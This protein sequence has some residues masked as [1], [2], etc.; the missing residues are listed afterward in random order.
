MANSDFKNKIVLGI[1]V[2]RTGIHD[3]LT[4]KKIFEIVLRVGNHGI[5]INKNY[6]K[7]F[8]KLQ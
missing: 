5:T 6:Q 7:I 8:F 4:E 2:Q 1:F 3:N